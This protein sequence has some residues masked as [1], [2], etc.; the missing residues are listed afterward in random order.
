MVANHPKDMF[1]VEH[2]NSSEFEGIDGDPSS[3]HDCPV[4]T[5]HMTA[6]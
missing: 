2:W 5:F 4:P 1:H 6:R 3:S